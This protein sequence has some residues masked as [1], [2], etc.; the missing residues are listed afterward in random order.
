MAKKRYISEELGMNDEVNILSD[1]EERVFTRCISIADDFGA[2]PQSTTMLRKRIGF[3]L[4]RH[5]EVVHALASLQKVGLLRVIIHDGKEFYT[6][7]PVR[8]DK[9][10]SH[11]KGKRTQSEYVGIKADTREE[12]ESEIIS[13]NFV[14][15]PRNYPPNEVLKYKAT[16]I[17]SK[18]ESLK[19]EPKNF[20]IPTL[21]E[22]VS[23]FTSRGSPSPKSEAEKFWNFY[24]A[25]GWLVGKTK[26]KKWKSAVAGWISRSKDFTTASEINFNGTTKPP[27]ANSSNTLESRQRLSVKLAEIERAHYANRSS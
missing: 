2:L 16:S 13:K 22:V 10:Q 11:I 8:F 25:K 24:E 26:M 20:Q 21:E 5:S 4:D 17:K 14:D 9:D 23:E 27:V 1:F 15:S 3:E 18:A 19:S 12:F 6:F 7:N